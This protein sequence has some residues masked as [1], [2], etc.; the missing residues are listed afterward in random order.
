M[1]ANA[2]RRA[3][4]GSERAALYF[5]A[6]GRCEEC[7]VALPPD[8][9]G[10]HIYPASKGGSTDVINGAALCPPCNL[11]KGD[12]V[13]ILRPWQQ[14]A[15]DKFSINE[16]TDFLAVAT[17]GA[18]KTRFALAAMRQ[19]PSF[20]VVVVP[21]T[22]LRRQWASAAAEAGIDLDPRFA[23]GDIRPGAECG[24]IVVTY[25]AVAKAP[26]IYR[27]LCGHH[28][29]AVL[30]EIH[31]CGDD[32]TW[33]DAIRQ[34]FEPCSRRLLLSG[35]P[36]RKP[37]SPI[38]FVTYE[39]EPPTSRTDYRYD[40]GAALF[41][42]VVRAVEFA[43]YDS[44][45]RWV[46]AGT[47]ITMGLSEAT[48]DDE[49][50]A[51]ASALMPD[52]EWMQLVLPEADRTLQRIRRD[53]TDAG[54]LL[55]AN[56]QF[57]AKA[58][59]QRLTAVIHRPVPVAIS[60]DP[61][62]RDIIE[63]FAA[64]SEPWLVA[65]NMV[66]EG[67]DIPRLMVGVYATS[68]RTDLF[69][70]QA[71]GRFVRVR[72]D[73]S[74]ACP[75]TLFVPSIKRLLELARDLE[76]ERDHVLTGDVIPTESTTSTPQQSFDMYEPL[77]A[78]DGRYLGS[79]LNGDQISDVEYKRAC[80]LIE[81]HGLPWNVAQLAVV[82]RDAGSAEPQ[83]APSSGKPR[84]Q[85]REQLRAEVDRLVKKYCRRSRRHWKDVWIELNDM[86]GEKAVKYAT[87]ETLEKRIM[88]LSEW[89]T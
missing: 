29:F 88:I 82:L 64:S 74:D 53:M 85:E 86:V 75:A 41:D 1:N 55:F 19:V 59:A 81:R 73:E 83:Q 56:D 22:P 42:G 23:N 60:E 27:K 35:T 63:R 49:G 12:K 38:P 67:V 15:L 52:S 2:G 14:E 7:G 20:Y 17:P 57:H 40:Y 26:H 72:G 68:Y 4:N 46:D 32:A 69:F 47:I 77:A 18:G 28:G 9:H 24:G 80:E 8:W 89:M 66:S 61:Q 30:D 58:L 44:T 25:S 34:A 33:G 37:T 51:L 76:I 48:R 65:V 79:I 71:T 21:S 10:D 45:A 36:F 70:R 31:H 11:R 84:Y 6:G 50:R 5:L 16:A 43:F 78:I 13:T 39:G 54:G 87:T 3:F 62:A